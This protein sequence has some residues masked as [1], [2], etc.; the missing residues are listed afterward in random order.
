MKYYKNAN[1][2]FLVSVCVLL[3]MLPLQLVVNTHLAIPTFALNPHT[4]IKKTILT[5]GVEPTDKI[6]RNIDYQL[7]PYVFNRF[8]LLTTI[9]FDSGE[10][11]KTQFLITFWPQALYSIKYINQ[12]VEADETKYFDPP[13]QHVLFDGGDEAF[14]V[15]EQSDSLYCYIQL[16]NQS[17]QCVDIGLKDERLA[18]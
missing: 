7:I 14:Q 1:K 6:A 8:I 16:S 17:V 4:T 5:Y 15:L 11:L 3:L 18:M 13:E 9:H 2:F 10:K 12:L